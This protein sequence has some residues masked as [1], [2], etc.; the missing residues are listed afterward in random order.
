MNSPTVPPAK[1]HPP[2]HLPPPP[3][4][5]PANP[6]DSF[7]F[8]LRPQ[9]GLVDHGLPFGKLLGE[10]NAQLVGAAGGDAETG[11]AILFA[12]VRPPQYLDRLP[13]DAIDRLLRGAGRS[14]E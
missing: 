12:D 2:P 6:A 13:G 11:Q 1:I 10:T 9:P 3:P 8:L 4:H 14:E 7:T 5:A